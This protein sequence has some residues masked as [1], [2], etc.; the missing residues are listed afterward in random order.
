MAYSLE[1][2]VREL[3][4]NESTKAILEQYLPGIYRKDSSI[5]QTG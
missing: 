3:L 4:G 5:E 2:T 1:S